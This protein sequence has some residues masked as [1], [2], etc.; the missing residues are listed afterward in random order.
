MAVT[1]EE[2]EAHDRGRAR[3]HGVKLMIAYRLHFERGE[4]RGGRDR[5][6][7]GQ[8]GEPR[9][10]NSVFT[11]QVRDEDNIRLR[12]E[13]RAAARST[14]SASTASTPRATCSATS[15]IEVFAVTAS[16]GEARFR[17]V[18]EMASGDPALSRASALATFTCSF[19][20]ADVVD[21]PAS[22][23]PKATCALEPAYEYAEGARRCTSRSKG[24]TR[25][26][27]FAKRDQFAPELLYFS[28]CVLEDRE[29]EPSG[30]EGLAD[31]RIIRA[32]YESA[33][34][35]EPVRLEPMPREARPSADQR[36]DRPPVRKPELVH[37]EPPSR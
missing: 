22:S 12:R 7:S 16:D 5:A 27:A 31:V 23:A 9:L 35:G 30:T 25:R 20:A 21:L 37:A 19:G 18:E 26:A 8:L 32:L 33:R 24:K 2:C 4:P 36:I 14:T 10:F 3:E 15:P 13:A 6:Q 34:L 11:M 1:E 28:D 17:E 29:P